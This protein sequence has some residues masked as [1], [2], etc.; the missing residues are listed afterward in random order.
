MRLGPLGAR[1]NQRQ[2]N[3]P[4]VHVRD[5]FFT[6]SPDSELRVICGF[7]F[8]LLLWTAVQRVRLLRPLAALAAIYLFGCSAPLPSTELPPGRE[9]AP[10]LEFPDLRDYRGI[11]DLR[12]KDA[13]LDQGAVADQ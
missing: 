10:A 13:K 4:I 1:V 9:V 5:H 2:K 8:T 12:I 7:C 11:V 3:S 6:A